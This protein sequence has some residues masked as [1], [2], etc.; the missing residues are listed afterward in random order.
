[1]NPLLR[2]REIGLGLPESAIFVTASGA[3]GVSE[4]AESKG[5]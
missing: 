1:M 3:N 2:A 5:T 4:E